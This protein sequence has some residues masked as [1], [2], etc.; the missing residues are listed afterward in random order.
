MP[1]S[2]YTKILLAVGA[3]SL[4]HC[5]YSAAQH[6]SYLRLTEQEFT[7]LPLDI[8]VQTIISLFLVFY[9]GSGVAGEFQPIRADLAMRCRTFETVA[10]CSSFY[11]F[12]HR[13]K[14][15]SPFFATGDFD[16]H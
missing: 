1:S 6:R 9:T 16:R 7:Y 5:A 13:A 11:V 14:A 4:I 10:N 2:S 12:D 15:L 3:V 8:F